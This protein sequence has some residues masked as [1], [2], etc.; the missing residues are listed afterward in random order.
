MTSTI[1]TSVSTSASTSTLPATAADCDWLVG[2]RIVV[3]GRLSGMSPRDFRRLLSAHDARLVKSG[4]ETATLVVVGD[5]LWPRDAAASP[6]VALDESTRRLVRQ[7]TAELIAESALWERIGLVDTTPDV[8]Q[9]YTPAMLASLL[10]VPL[11]HVRSWQRRGLLTPAC[12]VRKLA[13]FD[14]TQVTAARR[15]A[16][17][18]AAG[19]SAKAIVRSTLMLAQRFPDVAC[20]LGELPLVVSGRQLL[21]RQGE[22]LVD[23][24][25]QYRIDFDSVGKN[26]DG[27]IHGEIYGDDREVGGLTA[28]HGSVPSV[29]SP[30]AFHADAP[31][32]T[33]DELLAAAAELEEQGELAAAAEACRAAIMAGGPSAEVC[34]SLAE[35]LYRLGDLPAA[36]E[37]YYMAVELDEDFVEARANLGCVLAESGQLELAAAALAGALECHMDYADAHYHLARTLD[38][39]GRGEEAL[40]HW[41]RFAE[42]APDSPWAEEAR[43]RLEA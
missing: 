9:L 12:S 28:E 14:F 15:L 4:D 7:G 16:A 27:N 1:F 43:L 22:G 20:P 36:R 35:L 2:R 32:A 25:G 37:R 34:F 42:L 39:L 30:A 10:D 21:L 8:R 23:T 26:T 6:L 11:S 41:R 5:E 29:L 40:G 18:V 24:A 13:Y 38:E 3:V 17:L 19:V 33:A 31:V